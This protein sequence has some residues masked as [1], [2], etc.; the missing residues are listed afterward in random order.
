M[1]QQPDGALR[2]LTVS[3]L[4]AVTAATILER[5]DSGAEPMRLLA[6]DGQ[7]YWCKFVNNPH[8]IESV[9]FETLTS[10]I[11]RAIGAPIP[12]AATITI[13]DALRDK[14]FKDGNHIGAHGFGSLHVRGVIESDEVKH[15][16]RDGN[17]RRLPRLFA[18]SEL[19]MA[20]DFQVMYQQT[21][22]QRAFG[23]DFGFWM[24]N[25]G[26]PWDLGFVRAEAAES[27]TVLDWDG[28]TLDSD[29]MLE[30][31]S[32]VSRLTDQ[33]FQDAA[34]L[35]PNEW[36]YPQKLVDDLASELSK[37][38][39]LTLNTIDAKMREVA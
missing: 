19:C 13:P 30:T 32:I 26:G 29:A 33:T 39:T 7:M 36:N 11:G 3:K 27:Y 25:Y 17:P 1:K 9:V 14:R 23:L 21:D 24:G 22:D 4:P 20:Y 2:P 35:V 38:K 15:V 5:A 37:R 16:A 31:R 18:L 8:G 34:R 10:I 12:Q 28:I 6:T